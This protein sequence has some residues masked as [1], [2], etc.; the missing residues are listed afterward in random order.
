[1]LNNGRVSRDRTNSEKPR[2][3]VEE[4][5]RDGE[6]S[7][8]RILLFIYVNVSNGRNIIIYRIS[9][10]RDKSLCKGKHFFFFKF[11]RLRVNLKS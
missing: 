6:I 5:R 8:R 1:M 2:V 7:N 10:A 11:S 4:T 9:R 3:E